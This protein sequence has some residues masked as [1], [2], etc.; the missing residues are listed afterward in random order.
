MR[1]NVH[2]T[3]INGG[4][5]VLGAAGDSNGSRLASRQGGGRDGQRSR[6]I[7]GFLSHA[8]L[9][10]EEP[11]VPNYGLMEQRFALC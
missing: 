6:G 2:P 9:N 5:F 1:F 7:L 8:G 10:R 4:G 3:W 11:G